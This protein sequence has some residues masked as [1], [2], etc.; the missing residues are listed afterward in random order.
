MNKFI[1]TGD[2]L[3]WLLKH[4]C[5][6]TGDEIGREIGTTRAMVSKYILGQARPS[7]PKQRLIIKTVK[8]QVA[9]IK[10]AE[11]EYVAG[12]RSEVA[13]YLVEKQKLLV[14][15]AEFYGRTL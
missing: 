7:K 14:A 12:L 10:K 11:R 2:H 9:M 3:I 5:H 6:M 13:V 1:P 4:E 15:A 8:D